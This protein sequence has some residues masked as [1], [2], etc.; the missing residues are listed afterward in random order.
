MRTDPAYWLNQPKFSE[1]AARCVLSHSPHRL[2]RFVAELHTKAPIQLPLYTPQ[3]EALCP[4][5]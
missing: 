3:Q 1:A 2:D 5:A 4:P